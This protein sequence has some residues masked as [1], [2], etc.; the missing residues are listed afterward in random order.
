M[1]WQAK[2]AGFDTSYV[3]AIKYLPNQKRESMT[4]R[5]VKRSWPITHTMCLV[6]FAN[7]CVFYVVVT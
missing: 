1:T 2:C 3:R 7:A 4:E 5:K 6:T